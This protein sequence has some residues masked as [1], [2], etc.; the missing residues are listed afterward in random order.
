MTKSK[1]SFTLYA[2]VT[3]NDANKRSV[4]FLDSESDAFSYAESF[5]DLGNVSLTIYKVP[6]FQLKSC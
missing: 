4:Q 3:I 6:F 5:K 1:S 2:V